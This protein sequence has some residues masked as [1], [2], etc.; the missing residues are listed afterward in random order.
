MSEPVT[1]AEIE[2]VLSSIRRLVSDDGRSSAPV[3]DRPTEPVQKPAARL[4][5]TPS[6]RVADVA[7]DAVDDIG[8]REPVH[9]LDA[10][11]LDAY[12]LVNA[13]VED[14]SAQAITEAGA[15]PTDESLAKSLDLQQ[16]DSVFSEE[17][18]TE[19]FAVE[20]AEVE[21]VQAAQPDTILQTQELAPAEPSTDVPQAEQVEPDDAP[22][23]DPDATLYAAAGVAE[24]PAADGSAV[25]GDDKSNFSFADKIAALEA[26]IGQAEEQW[27]PDGETDEEYSGTA[28]ETLDWEDLEEEVAE[29]VVS[30]ADDVVEASPQFTASPEVATPEVDPLNAAHLAEQAVADEVLGDFAADEAIMD[31]E[32]LRELVADIVREE[33]QG[34][35]GER[36]T[37]NV[38]KLVR[39]EIH[40]A[41]AVQDLS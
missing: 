20:P 7:L 6:L 38:R 4:V 14:T 28:V 36:I 37:R 27:E 32:T 40:R 30:A 21:P 39:R 3:A 17:P 26:A 12:Q 16:A 23:R 2:D 8:S 15:T 22:W 18:S 9:K 5:L 29:P 19:A 35:L 10:H 11:K 34:A 24:T 25:L 1:H 33:L 13:E 41:L 31:E